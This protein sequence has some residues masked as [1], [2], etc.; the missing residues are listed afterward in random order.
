MIIEFFFF[1]ILGLVFGSFLNSLIFRFYNNL[2]LWQRSFCPECKKNIKTRD[3]IPLLSFF[4]L[5]GKCRFCRQKISWQYFFVE[6]IVGIVFVLFFV[7]YAAL[8]LFLIRDLFFALVLIFIFVFDLRYYLILDKV[9]WPALIISLIL[10]FFLGLNWLDLIFGLMIGAG[11]FGLQY[12]LS[13]NWVGVGDIK[14]GALIGVMLGWPLVILAIAL[15]YIIGGLT[16]IYLLI[17][18]RKKFGDILPMGTF[19]SAATIVILLLG[20]KMLSWYF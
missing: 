18:G 14:L 12:L 1:F 4:L 6:L 10:N 2:P 15:A 7:K 17:V 8:N 16:A 19:L 20:E 5:G 11:F 3:L 13:K 9:V